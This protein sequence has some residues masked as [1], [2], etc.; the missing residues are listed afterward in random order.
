MF[1]GYITG[2]AVLGGSW[3]RL[4]IANWT[5]RVASVLRGEQVRK[6]WVRAFSTFSGII[7]A[8]IARLWI[9]R[10]A[11][12]C[13]NLVIMAR[14]TS[15][16]ACVIMQKNPTLDKSFIIIA[17]QTDWRITGFALPANMI[18]CGRP[19]KCS[20]FTHQ[21]VCRWIRWHRNRLARGKPRS[22]DARKN[23]IIDGDDIFCHFYQITSHILHCIGSASWRKSQAIEIKLQRKLYKKIRKRTLGSRYRCKREAGSLQILPNWK[24][25]SQSQWGR[26]LIF[27]IKGSSCNFS[28]IIIS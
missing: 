8:L 25:M 11:W 28:N 13:G 15:T 27:Y 4:V 20:G 19:D 10:Q 17:G 5:F 16:F 9:T 14:R 26:V 18:A 23:K 6:R 2:Q 1:V 24:R 7:D 12:I 21:I 3:S 22:H